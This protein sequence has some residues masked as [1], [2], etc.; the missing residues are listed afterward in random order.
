MPIAT[1]APT[2]AGLP[3]SRLDDDGWPVLGPTRLTIHR[4]SPLDARDRQI[5]MSL[6]GKKICTLM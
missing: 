5:I 2:A 3:A 1:D 6:D 4:T